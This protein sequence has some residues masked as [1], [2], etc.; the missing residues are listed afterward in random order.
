LCNKTDLSDLLMLRLFLTFLL[1]GS[2]VFSQ[3]GI[4]TNI[5]SNAAGLRFKQ[6]PSITWNQGTAPSGGLSISL[7]L[8]RHYQV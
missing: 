4:I 7:D 1:F 5:V 8:S 2:F 3:A 6:L